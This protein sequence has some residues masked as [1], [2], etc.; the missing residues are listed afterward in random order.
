MPANKGL[1]RL[2]RARMQKT[3][4]SYTAARAQ[5]TRKPKKKSA[6]A[7]AA[8]NPA[9]YATLA[10]MSDQVVKDKTGCT[11][12]RWVKALDHHGADTMS[13]AAIAKLVRD[14]YKVGPWWGQMVTVG[15]E[16]IKGLRARGQQRDGSYGAS[17]S[18]TY[19]VP[20]DT[21]YDA[22]ASARTRKR[23]LDDAGVKIRTATR[24][25]S[26]RLD[27]PDGGIVAVG[28]FAKGDG[29]SS[30]ALEHTKLPDRETVVRLK[31]YWAERLDALGKVLHD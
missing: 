12:T 29:K 31:T 14:T 6:V 19:N 1:K 17:K 11:W 18:K 13:H 26:M 30:V 8:A 22:W 9:D 7:L 27:W 5:I 28:F 4:E 20:I 23:W 15:Y 2:V 10:G 16:R 24:P 21:L 3:A 25:K